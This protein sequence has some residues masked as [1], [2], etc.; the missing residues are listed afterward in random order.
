[1]KQYDIKT[2]NWY[3]GIRSSKRSRFFYSLFR[4]HT[5]IRYRYCE[6]IFLRTWFPIRVLKLVG[7]TLQV[8]VISS[9]FFILSFTL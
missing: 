3:E 5:I 9:T 8:I 7:V 1:M 6:V 2:L 4:K